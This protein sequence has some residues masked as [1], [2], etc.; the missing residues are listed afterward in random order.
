MARVT[1]YV[2]GFNL[3]YGLREEGWRRYYWLNLRKM[4]SSLMMANQ[5]LIGI[6]YFTSLVSPT[7]WDPDKNRRQVA[8]L[9]ALQT[10]QDLHVIYGHYLHNKQTCRKCGATWV[11]SDEKMTDVN[12][13]TELMVDAFQNSFDTALI[14]SADSDLS[15]PIEAVRRLFPAKRVVVFFPPARSSKR[16]MQVASGYFKIRRNTLA[17]SQFPDQVSTSS[18][19]TIRRPQSWK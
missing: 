2:D 17:Q 16:L 18:G 1:A 8:Y 6:K 15:G 14:V 3:Y 7:P 12:I 10:L 13:A 19:V 4:I 11:A 5:T 9:D